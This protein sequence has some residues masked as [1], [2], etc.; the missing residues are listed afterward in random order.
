MAG[1][2]NYDYM[3]KYLVAIAAL[4][5]AVSCT[6]QQP[7]TK[8]EEQDVPLSE[9]QAL[10][11]EVEELKATIA[12]LTPGST[13]PSAPQGTEVSKDEF[14]SLKR[15][16]ATLRADFEREI[17]ALTE[18]NT[19]LKAQ[20]GLFTSGFFEV[21][22]LR[23]D[24]NGTLISVPKLEARVDERIGNNTLTTTRQYDAEGRV[25]E[26]MQ[27]YNT[28]SEWAGVPFFWQKT[29]Y[30]YSGKKCKTTIQTN[31]Y[32]LDAGKPYEET[33]TEATFW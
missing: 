26:I 33:I 9:F 17:G 13:D 20:I 11:K 6:K 16:Y 12:S 22:G 2:L 15:E 23:F 1:S 14:D 21:D 7:D 28:H 18:E 32:G 19:A 24:R 5:L 31:K 10:K 4:F 30:E 25:I 29:V 8:P 3:K 27:D